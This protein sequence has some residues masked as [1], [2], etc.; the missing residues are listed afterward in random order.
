MV[1]YSASHA[2]YYSPVPI[3]ELD[4]NTGYRRDCEGVG[5][6]VGVPVILCSSRGSSCSNTAAALVFRTSFEEDHSYW[7]RHRHWPLTPAIGTGGGEKTC[8]AASTTSSLRLGSLSGRVV[9]MSIQFLVLVVFE[10]RLFKFG[11]KWLDCC[12]G[13]DDGG[14]LNED[15]IRYEERRS[16]RQFNRCIVGH[17]DR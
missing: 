17:V 2:P 3:P 4:T 13:A 11:R 14:S 16:W 6:W 7:R 8:T 10:T 5:N 9:T 1:V 15:V 12:N